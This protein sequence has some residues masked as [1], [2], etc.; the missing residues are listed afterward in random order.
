MSMPLSPCQQFP[1]S[2]IGL[3]SFGALPELRADELFDSLVQ[4]PDRTSGMGPRVARIPT[5]SRSPAVIQLLRLA[6]SPI[7]LPWFPASL[8]KLWF[9]AYVLET[10]TFSY[11]A[12][13]GDLTQTRTSTFVLQEVQVFLWTSDCRW[14]RPC[15]C[16][17]RWP[18]TGR[19]CHCMCDCF[20]YRR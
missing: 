11:A 3:Q 10:I 9:S 16:H 14:H 17:C 15:S 5:S 19:L 2:F 13:A 18:A 6:T 12:L 20:G 8:A 4:A 1:A 7:T